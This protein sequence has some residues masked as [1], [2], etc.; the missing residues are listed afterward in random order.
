LAAPPFTAVLL[1]SGVRL[2]AKLAKGAARLLREACG[3]PALREH[4][5]VCQIVDGQVRV[6]PSTA[7][8]AR[9][10]GVTRARI[11]RL[12]GALCVTERGL[13]I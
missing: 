12:V 4:G 5:P 8:A 1:G 3:L 10:N 2:N 9:R 13:W 7:E 6:Y 11:F